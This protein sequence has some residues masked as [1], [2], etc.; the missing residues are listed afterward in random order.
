VQ[1]TSTNKSPIDTIIEG[2]SAIFKRYRL[3]SL[4]LA[5]RG[6]PIFQHR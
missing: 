6:W 5:D 3:E 2:L 4:N 1:A